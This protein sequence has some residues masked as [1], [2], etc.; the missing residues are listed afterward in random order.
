MRQDERETVMDIDLASVPR[1]SPTLLMSRILATPHGSR[2][3]RARSTHPTVRHA[4]EL[5][6]AA[7]NHR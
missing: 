7:R 6:G 2:A 1:T 5:Q 3:Q 4:I